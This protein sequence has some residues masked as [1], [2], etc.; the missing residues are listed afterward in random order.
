MSKGYPDYRDFS[1]PVS[2]SEGGTGVGTLTLYGVLLGNG[3]SQ[4]IACAAGNPYEV[5]RVPALGGFP[6][7]GA[8]DLSQAAAVAGILAIAN[9]GTGT[10][11][12]GITA[13]PNIVITNVWP[14]QAISLGDPLSNTLTMGDGLGQTYFLIDGA[15]GSQRS[16]YFR[17]GSI[18]RWCLGADTDAEGGSNSGSGFRLLSCKDDGSAL[19]TAIWVRRS[20]GQVGIGNTNPGKKLDVTGDVRASGE[21]SG[22]SVSFTT[23]WDGCRVYHSVDQTLGSSVSTALAFD[24]ERYD[25][26]GLHSTTSNNSRLTAQKDGTYLITG[27]VAFAANASG[28]RVVGI[29][30]NPTLFIAQTE[31]APV[32]GDTD[33]F[34]VTTVYH[35]AASDYVELV[36]YQNS[37]GDL[38]VQAAGNYSAEFAMQWLSP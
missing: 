37:G 2:V 7:F 16:V 8:L 17:T 20:D 15:A 21:V 24:S 25:N 3:T 30:K 4:I 19:L 1:F 6:A 10:N 14:T 35:L 11:A 36:A 38:A 29:R 9:G 5:L 28:V 27:H 26:G 34:S 13:G 23:P 12:P 33:K 32:G 22:A 31:R 18:N